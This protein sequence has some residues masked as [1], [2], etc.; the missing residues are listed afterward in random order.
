VNPLDVANAAGFLGTP[1]PMIPGV[2]F[3]GIVVS[4][5]DHTGQK[6][7]GS[8]PELGAK[9]PGTHARFVTLD[10]Y[11]HERRLT[12]LA[13]V[14]MDGAHVANIFDQIRALFDRGVLTPRP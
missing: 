6:V 3:A 2:D 14:F 11:G 9:R 5:G 8:A 7:W 4:D 13:S 10:F 1:L 12:G